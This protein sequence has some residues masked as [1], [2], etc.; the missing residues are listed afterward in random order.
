MNRRM[1][2]DNTFRIRLLGGEWATQMSCKEA[3]CPQWASG[4]FSVIDPSTSDGAWQANWIK[5]QSHRIFYEWRS[6]VA[7][8]EAL[9]IDGA[10]LHVTPP[11]RAMLAGLASGLIVFAFP[12]GQTCFAQHLDRE[13]KFMHN[14][15][16]HVRPRDF[17]EDW[18]IEGDKYNT[19]VRRG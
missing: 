4:W 14:Q 18:N 15:Y 9:A 12:A 3:H 17:N 8:D 5:T 2:R 13:I 19:A 16:E 6:D 7:L 11:L 1:S 10:D